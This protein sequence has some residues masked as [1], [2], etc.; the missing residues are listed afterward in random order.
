[1]LDFL[2]PNILKK[3]GKKGVGKR[4]NSMPRKK[5]GQS[6]KDRQQITKYFLRSSTLEDLP[7]TSVGNIENMASKVTDKST[8]QG[9]QPA[10]VTTEADKQGTVLVQQSDQQVVDQLQMTA[11][12]GTRRS[13]DDKILKALESLEQ[14]LESKID[15]L[16]TEII[17]ELETKIS[18]VAKKVQDIETSINYAHKEIGDLKVSKTQLE[19]DT[20][21]LKERLDSTQRENKELKGQLT[22]AR[23]HLDERLNE[24]ERYSR[25]YGIRVYNVPNLPKFGR[26][27]VYIKL[28]ATLLV[29]NALVDTQDARAAEGLIE[30]VHPI[31]RDSGQLIAKLYSRPVRNNI[32][33]SAKKKLPRQDKALHFAE[34]MTRADFERKKKAIPI[35][36]SA[37][38][39][40]KKAVFRNGKLIVDGQICKIPG[41]D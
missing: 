34:D 5:K 12:P 6:E 23:A 8:E 4:E 1:M 35:M 10:L 36:Q 21:R 25:N 27:E 17:G 11:S 22:D 9:V 38:R 20:K 31:G 15:C 41:C 37:Y 24:M 13:S 28:L 19:H 32:L 7:S 16:K 30:T 39:D 26:P 2:S 33:Q 3:S 29:D 40:G 18:G 14:R